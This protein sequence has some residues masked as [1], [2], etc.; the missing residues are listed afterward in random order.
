MNVKRG[1]MSAVPSMAVAPE[2]PLDTGSF[3]PSADICATNE[4]CLPSLAADMTASL[5]KANYPSRLRP[6]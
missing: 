3:V 4:K 5:S 6:C 2:P 1:R